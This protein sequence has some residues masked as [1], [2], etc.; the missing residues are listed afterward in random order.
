MI[1]EVQCPYCPTV[2]KTRHKH[3]KACTSCRPYNKNIMDMKRR[4]EVKAGLRITSKK[5]CYEPK[6]VVEITNYVPRDRQCDMDED[7]Q[8]AI[9]LRVDKSDHL[10]ME[11]RVLRPGDPDFDAI[12]R[13]GRDP[14][15]IRKGPYALH[16][17]DLITAAEPIRRGNRYPENWGAAV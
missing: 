6:E 15:Y 3:A 16:N 2:F 7:T 17:Y 10:K 8:A 1:Y 5:K 4:E 9:N 13:Q 12:A 11:A 14:K